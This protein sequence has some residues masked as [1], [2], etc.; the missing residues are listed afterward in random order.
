[1]IFRRRRAGRTQKKKEGEANREGRE[2][3]FA[4]K[5]GGRASHASVPRG[6]AVLSHAA[7]APPPFLLP[8]RP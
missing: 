3:Y 4:E 2:G 8:R 7:A 5:A 6:D 1:V